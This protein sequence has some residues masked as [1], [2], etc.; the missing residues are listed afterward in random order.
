[1]KSVKYFIVVLAGLGMA[2]CNSGEEEGE[3]ANGIVPNEVKAVTLRIDGLS[4]NGKLRSLDDKTLAKHTINLKDLTLVFTDGT[5]VYQTETLSATVNPDDFTAIQ[6]DEGVTY[7]KVNPAVTKVL[8]VGNTV[9]KTITLTPVAAVRASLAEAEKEQGKDNVT[10]YGEG[11][12]VP[13]TPA[14]THPDTHPE[15]VTAHYTTEVEISPLVARFEIDGIECMDLGKDYASFVLKGLG[16]VDIYPSV[17]LDR[18]AFAGKWT[19][20][21]ATNTGGLFYEPGKTS[22]VP[23]GIEFGSPGWAYEA[24][25]NAPFDETTNTYEAEGGKVFAFNFIAKAGEFPN[26]KL[27]L[28]EVAPKTALGFANYEYVSTRGFTG[29]DATHPK[30]GYIY[31]FDLTFAEAN[32]G[33]WDPDSKKCINVAVKV[34]EWEIVS[35]NPAFH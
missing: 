11:D 19:V 25:S 32:I 4:H 5:A 28:G 10:L 21:N 33:P 29:A 24:I 30:P 7:H 1:M 27:R 34:M 22:P 17:S 35:V 20:Y 15:T 16:L 2:A 26:I 6:G 12:L 13:A 23:G 31:Q 14:Y 9:G 3:G 18:S 8:V